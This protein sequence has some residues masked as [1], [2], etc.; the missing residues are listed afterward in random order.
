MYVNTYTEI[1]RYTYM[2][3]REEGP[4]AEDKF[5]NLLIKRTPKLES[6]LDH[7]HSLNVRPNLLFA[8]KNPPPPKKN[9]SSPPPIRESRGLSIC[10]CFFFLGGGGVLCVW[11]SVLKQ[12]V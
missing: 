1:Y 4:P 2:Y 12:I 11:G 6:P 10:S 3:E 9:R 5:A 8:Y 7:R